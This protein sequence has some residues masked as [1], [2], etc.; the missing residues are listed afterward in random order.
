MDA[1]PTFENM[2]LLGVLDMLEKMLLADAYYQPLDTNDIQR[3]FHHIRY[4]N[5]FELTDA[6][7]E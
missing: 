5:G 6:K 1:K 7:E 2:K 3:I 4:E